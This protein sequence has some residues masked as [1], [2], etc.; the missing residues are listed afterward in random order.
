MAKNSLQTIF[1]VQKIAEYTIKGYAD[2]KEPDLKV[3]SPALY[4]VS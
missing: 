2:A 4:E 3:Y 1:I